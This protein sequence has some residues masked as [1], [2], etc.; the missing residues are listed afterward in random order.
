MSF[1]E[2]TPADNHP[3]PEEA[4]DT[5]E[6]TLPEATEETGEAVPT[7]EP[8]AAEETSEVLPAPSKEREPSPEEQP[9]T[10][11][12]ILEQE[13]GIGLWLTLAIGA[14]GLL[15]M[16]LLPWTNIYYLNPMQKLVL[17]GS[18]IV[19]TQ[20]QVVHLM[21]PG[22]ALLT[23]NFWPLLV[24]I[25]LTALLFG[26]VLYWRQHKFAQARLAWLVLA[27]GLVIGV[28]FPLELQRM[29][30]S[31]QRV[32][33]SN[34]SGTIEDNHK[35]RVFATG[36]SIGLCTPTDQNDHTCDK[37][38]AQGVIL[39][40]SIDWTQIT[41]EGHPDVLVRGHANGLRASATSPDVTTSGNASGTFGN[42]GT[43]FGYWGSWL[44]SI[45]ILL[46]ALL[47]LRRLLRAR[48]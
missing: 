15:L 5:V 1:S 18:T 39:S 2:E 19:L 11:R 45:W 17:N 35:I 16:L 34:L 42:L 48:R 43:S 41:S 46:N 29:L 4:P 36:E 31:S 32:E 47:L 3:T 40:A 8:P 33:W 28:G 27:L 13:S 14:A 38:Y 12:E 25:L 9:L 24:L 26:T 30:V 37:Y 20:D 23:L 21:I 22:F 44:L 7:N 10:R 6:A